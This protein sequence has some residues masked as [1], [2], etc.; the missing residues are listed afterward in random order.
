MTQVF[1]VQDT[2]VLDAL[3]IR[4]FP[5]IKQGMKIPHATVEFEK[6]SQHSPNGFCPLGAYSYSH[7]ALIGVAYV[8]RY[9]SIAENVRV[10]GN[11]HPVNWV[12]TSPVF[13][14][15]RRMKRFGVTEQST[16][17]ARRYDEAP[18][19]VTI[20][21]DFWIGQDVLLR[22]GISV[23]TGAVIAA[24]SVVVKDVPDYAIVGGNP[25]K[26]IRY[27]FEDAVI[28]DIKASRWWEYAAADIAD[29]EFDSPKAFV[30]GLDRLTRLSPLR[31]ER[32]TIFQHLE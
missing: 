31:L 25:A 19:P 7:S 22:D 14:K 8:G 12:S 23:G 32:R 9:C 30:A 16:L 15:P 29:M 4:F 6:F 26:I 10:M 13:Y 18:K 27:R 11:S 1:E 24:G 3:E 20:G 21:H 2:G 17:R 5:K 28:N